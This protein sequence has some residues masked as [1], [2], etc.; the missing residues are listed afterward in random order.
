MMKS[1]LT[2]LKRFDVA[3]CCLAFAQFCLSEVETLWK[4]TIA[5]L[6]LVMQ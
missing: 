1:L 5:K 6:P 4:M 2:V 3:F